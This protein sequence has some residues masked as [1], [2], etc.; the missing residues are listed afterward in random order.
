MVLVAQGD[1]RPHL[2]A[3]LEEHRRVLARHY[4]DCAVSNAVHDHV[5]RGL[6]LEAAQDR[7]GHVQD[8]GNGFRDRLLVLL[9]VVEQRAG[10]SAE[11]VHDL[12]VLGAE[13]RHS[14]LGELDDAHRLARG[15]DE[16]AAEEGG[17][18]LEVA[19]Q[20]DGRVEAGVFA[21]VWH[22]DGA[23]RLHHRPRKPLV[24][25][26]GGVGSLVRLRL[27][28]LHVR[29]KP[30]LPHPLAR[31][32][33]LRVPHHLGMLVDQQQYLPRVRR[34]QLYCL[35]EN[36][37]GDVVRAGVDGAEAYLEPHAVQ[38]LRVQHRLER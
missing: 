11:H 12:D 1:L 27:R 21:D 13:L 30:D 14:A 35:V 31:H 15:G 7:G 33:D 22:V 38:R 19:L 20:V 26:V 10:L 24:G 8:A 16:G 34:Y 18:A 3:P 32:R 17:V 37:A 28:P 4:V 36:C 29:Q 25:V 2:V 6:H 5:D 23:P 9:A